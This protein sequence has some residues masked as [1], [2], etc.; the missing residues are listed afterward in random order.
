MYLMTYSLSL[1]Y[2]RKHLQLFHTYSLSGSRTNIYSTIM[3]R[4][5]ARDRLSFMWRLELRTV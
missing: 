2:K 1:H 4:W 3:P 5:Y